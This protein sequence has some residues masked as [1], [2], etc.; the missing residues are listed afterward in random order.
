MG[1]IL[2]RMEDVHRRSSHE[3]SRSGE[4]EVGIG[5]GYLIVAEAR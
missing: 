3:K 5:G 4:D 2:C 1:V